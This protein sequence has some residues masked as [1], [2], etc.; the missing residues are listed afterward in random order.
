MNAANT[1]FHYCQFQ[2]API[3]KGLFLSPSLRSA[4]Q[5]CLSPPLLSSAD[6]QVATTYRLEAG[7]VQYSL[8]I[9]ALPNGF[10]ALKLLDAD[11]NECTVRQLTIQH[12]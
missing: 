9:A 7:V 5:R 11:G 6:A 3:M 8:D 10:Y 1:F 12:P 2:L 4:Q